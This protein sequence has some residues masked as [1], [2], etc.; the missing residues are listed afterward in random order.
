MARDLE[1]KGH[2]SAQEIWRNTSDNTLDALLV[3]VFGAAAAGQGRGGAKAKAKAKAK[4][5]GKVPA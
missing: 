3:K 4:N 5:K 2:G 1:R